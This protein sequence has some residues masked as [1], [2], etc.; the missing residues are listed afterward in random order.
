VLLVA[1]FLALQRSSPLRAHDAFLL[2]AP[3]M[4]GV[5]TLIGIALLAAWPAAL[6]PRYLNPMVPSFGLFVALAWRR[7]RMSEGALLGLALLGSCIVGLL[8]FCM[9]AS[10]YFTNVGAA[11]GIHAA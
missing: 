3:L 1:A 10:H 6:F 4:L 7:A 9:V 8:W 11:L 2:A 5:A